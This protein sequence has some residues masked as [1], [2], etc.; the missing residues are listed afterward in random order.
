MNEIE[1]KVLIKIT[2]N[3]KDREI[4][5][6]VIDN[7]R[8]EI[9]KEIKKRNLEIDI[10]LVGS[11]AKDTYLKNNLDIDYFLCFPKEF[12]KENISRYALSIGKSILEKPEESYAEHPYIRGYF[13][14][15]FVEIVPCYI[16]KDISQKASAVDRTPLHTKFIKDNIK[17]EEKG[18]VRLLKQFLRGIN[19][20]G[21]EAEIQ[22][23]SGY[24]C[25]LLI[26]KYHS[27]ER[28]LNDLKKWK[29][30]V[31]LSLS[32]IEIKDFEDPLIFIDPVDKDRNVASAVS[33][34][35][36]N[37]FKNA[38]KKYLA[39][40]KTTFFFPNKIKVWAN[41]KIK[42]E[43]E[44]Q[45]CKYIAIRF[46]KPDI[47]DE[48]LYPQI[49]K[50][51]KSVS[52]SAER[53]DFNILDKDF[54]IE[55]KNKSIYMIFKTDKED[56]TE[57]IE[58]K[59]PPT[60]LRKNSREFMKKWKD[61]KRV[62]KK[63]YEKNDRLYV[64]LK[65][66]YRNFKDFLDSELINLSLGKSIDKIIEKNYKLLENDDLII[67]SLAEFWTKYLDNKMPWER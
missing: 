21:A 2:P 55:E 20:Y 5:E 22:G 52:D 36:F 57:T 7:L 42:R 32:N 50:A 54:F 49:R 19:C 12:K 28:L 38:G 24:L 63:P 4:L 9:V 35:K 26:L 47:I 10:E 37:L 66:E 3:S 23:F 53:F 11:T 51:A 16:I 58:H 67:D 30:K 46:E 33:F 25:E 13:K 61:D 62:I 41:K 29:E 48:N 6:R 56:L 31:K 27:F 18:E 64:E 1:K 65:R 34:E 45:N 14:N 43:I 40:P 15:F 8:K 17:E 60:K 44:K 59:G 39:M